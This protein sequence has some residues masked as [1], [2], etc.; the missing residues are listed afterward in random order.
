MGLNIACAMPK[1]L[2]Q[3]GHGH[4]ELATHNFLRRARSKSSPDTEVDALADRAS[5]TIQQQ[6]LHNAGVI[7]ARSDG[8]VCTCRSAGTFLSGVV[9]HVVSSAVGVQV[10][11]E[12]VRSKH[13]RESFVMDSTVTPFGVATVVVCVWADSELRSRGERCQCRWRCQRSRTWVGGVAEVRSEGF[14]FRSSQRGAESVSNAGGVCSTIHPE[15]TV[16]ALTR[17]GI[18]NQ[19]SPHVKA[20]GRRPGE[21]I[22]RSIDSHDVV[23][24]RR[25]NVCGNSHGRYSGR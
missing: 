8:C 10:I 17:R 20:V 15:N 4:L 6:R 24:I 21:R 11:N 1:F 14:D 23:R 18:P 9:I 3:I 16:A 12:C 2:P 25:A 13:R 5:A 22:A 19:P 7:T